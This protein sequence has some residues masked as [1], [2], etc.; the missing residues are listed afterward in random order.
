MIYLDGVR[1]AT[2]IP[3]SIAWFWAEKFCLN[4]IHKRSHKFSMTL[5]M[6]VS[7]GK[8]I[9]CASVDVMLGKLIVVGIYNS[10][11]L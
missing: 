2:K 7:T 5:L 10:G 4:V 9:D 8:R 6:Y 11:K 1:T 3:V